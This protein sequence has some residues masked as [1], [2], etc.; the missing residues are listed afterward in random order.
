[1]LSRARLAGLVTCLMVLAGC[2]GTSDS[3]TVPDGP[4]PSPTVA[5]TESLRSTVTVRLS[6]IEGARGDRIAGVL[7]RGKYVKG[8]EAIG[9]FSVRVDTDPYSGARVVTKPLRRLSGDFPYVG[10]DPVRVRPGWY[11]LV[12]WKGPSL[13]G[14]SGWGRWLPGGDERDRRL[15]PVMFLV[16]PGRTATLEVTAAPNQTDYDPIEQCATAAPPPDDALGAVTVHL[17][18]ID[19]APGDRVAGVLF[20]GRVPARALLYGRAVGGFGVDTGS[21]PL[22]VS[23]TVNEGTGMGVGD[24]FPYV[25]DMPVRL[26]PG[27]YVLLVWRG[28]TL[29]PYSRWIPADEPGLAVCQV[30]VYVVAGPSTTVEVT[31]MPRQ[32][33]TLALEHLPRCEGR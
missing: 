16:S 5:G 19:H 31:G 27:W 2:S 33:R 14:P 23:R 15:C 8:T 7:Y 11:N 4:S 17:F 20:K 12:L 3:G 10:D 30:S 1:M 25:S 24:Q 9:G 21:E 13:Q 18:T 22:T 26:P 29:G 28:P 32:P 6:G